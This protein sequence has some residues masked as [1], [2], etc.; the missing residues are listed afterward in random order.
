MVENPI[1]DTTLYVGGQG[2]YRDLFA[3]PVVLRHTENKNIVTTF[4]VGDLSIIDA[5]RERSN[6]TGRLNALKITPSKAGK[7][8]VEILAED[9]C[10]AVEMNFEVTVVDSTG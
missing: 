8:T 10:E 2:F 1:P 3:E 9:D 5:N 7:T 6:T 4:M